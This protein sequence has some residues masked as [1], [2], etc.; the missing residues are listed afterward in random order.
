[1]NNCIFCKIIKGEMSA[2]KV[3]ED[4]RLLAFLDINP[5]NAG[6]TLLVSKEHYEN[7]YDLPDDILRQMAPM[8]KK[9]AMAIKEAV[10]AQGINIG[11]NNEK[12]AGQLVP[13]AHFHI[14]PR[15]SNDGHRH[16]HGEPYLEGESQQTAEKIKEAL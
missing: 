5:V 1:M 2:D 8:I 4:D 6:H 9:L 10:G 3:Y 15:F 11:M 7:L 12:A 13:H 14:I 16:W